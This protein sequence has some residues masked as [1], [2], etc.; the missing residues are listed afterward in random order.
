[1]EIKQKTEIHSKEISLREKENKGR[2]VEKE[3]ILVRKKGK[4]SVKEKRKEHW[5][6]NNSGKEK[7]KRRWRG[8]NSGKE[9][10]GKAHWKKKER[11]WRKK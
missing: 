6:G 4:N 7:R 3:R 1:M 2:P 11:C 9:K 10:K 8:K 5:K